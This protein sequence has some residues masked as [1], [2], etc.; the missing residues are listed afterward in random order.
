MLL[1]LWNGF[2]IGSLVL[3]MKSNKSVP[4]TF[5][6]GRSQRAHLFT[7]LLIHMSKS[8]DEEDTFYFQGV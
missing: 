7:L 1:N 6:D 5:I 2:H 4:I 8:C 3:L